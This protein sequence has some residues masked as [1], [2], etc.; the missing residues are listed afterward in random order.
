ETYTGLEGRKILVAEDNKINFFVVNKFLSG[1]GVIVTHAEDGQLAIEKLDN[2]DF[3]LI[4]MD[5]HMPVMDGIEATQAI[6]SSK[7]PR[8]R[9]IP[10]VALTAAI[11]SENHDRLDQLNINDYVLKPFKP[12]D[13]F[14]RIKKH[15]R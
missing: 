6:R 4:L 11:M 2:E 10:I 14:E 3:D 12:H 5:L 15:I 1:W 7:D 13:L 9:D 8:I